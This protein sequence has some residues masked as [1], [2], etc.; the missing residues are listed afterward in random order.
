MIYRRERNGREFILGPSMDRGEHNIDNELVFSNHTGYVFHDSRGIESGGIEE[1]ETLKEFIRRK[2]GEKKLRDKLHAIWYCVPMDGHR[3]GLDLRFYK[4]ICPDQNVPVIAVFTK[5]DQFLF[6]VEMDV[7]DDPDKYLNKSV[8]E[9]AK[10]QF[11]EHYLLPLGEDVRYVQL[12]KMHRKGGH[13]FELI[14][15]TAA[16]LNE[17]AVMLM[18]LAVQRGNVELSVKTAW[19]RVHCL[20]TFEIEHVIQECLF[21]F[22]YTW[23]KSELLSDE[24]LELSEN[25]LLFLEKLLDLD[26]ELSEAELLES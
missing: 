18:L 17:D 10:E 12:E 1:L 2:C 22:P 16:A 8:S 13:C 3:P 20:V 25:L 5:Y 7:L 9:V 14:E 23:L 4:N 26:E 15:K 6:N 24:K 21:A 11:Y 19:R